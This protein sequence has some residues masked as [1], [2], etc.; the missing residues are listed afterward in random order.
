VYKKLER[1]DTAEGRVYE[2]D[3]SER[4]PSVTTILS[5]TKDKT[6]L[7]EWAARVRGAS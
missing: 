5:E 6:H 1:I 3:K 7:K 2:I 4:L